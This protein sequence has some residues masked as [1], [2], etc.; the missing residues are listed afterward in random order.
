MNKTLEAFA[1]ILEAAAPF[2]PEPFRAGARV[3]T[4]AISAA[5]EAFKV[6]L[7]VELLAL[8][9]QA[10]GQAA[11]QASKMAGLRPAFVGLVSVH[12]SMPPDSMT[13]QGF[14]DELMAEVTRRVGQ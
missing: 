11:Y 13:V 10:A 2:I 12:L 7:P 6:T 14:V 4:I 8:Q 1:S 9:G 3:A 5:D